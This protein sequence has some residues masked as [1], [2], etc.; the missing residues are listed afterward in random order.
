MPIEPSL[1]AKGLSGRGR[2]ALVFALALMPSVALAQGEPLSAIDW[3]SDTVAHPTAKPSPMEAPVR[4]PATPDKITTSTLLDRNLDAVSVLPTSITGIDRRF[5]SGSSSAALTDLIRQERAEA[6]PA[7]RDLLQ[8][9]MLAELDPPADSDGSGTFL[10]VRI[11]KLLELGA[12]EAASALVQAAGKPTPEL[13]RRAFDI[14]LLLATEDQACAELRATPQI[15]PT[16]PA[17]IFCLARGGNWPAAE[18]TLRTAQALGQVTDEED[19]LLERFLAPGDFEDAE[20]LP[21]PE[22]LSPLVLRIY[23]AIG[24]PIAASSLPLAFAHGDLTPATGW[25]ARL[26]AAER[27]ARTAAIAPGQLFSLYRERRPAA[28][29]G[30]WTRVAAVQ[31][32]EA[33]LRER[34]LKRLGTELDTTWSVLADQELEVPFAEIH[35]ASLALLPLEGDAGNLAFRIGLLGP[36]YEKI[37]LRRTPVDEMETFLIGIARGR[38][39]GTVPPY[40]MARAIAPVFGAD[41]TAPPLSPAMQA[42]VEEGRRGEAALLAIDK[43]TSGVFGDL[44]GVTDGLTTLRHLGLEGSARRAALQ[45]MLLERRG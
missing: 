29:G 36:G 3:L 19:A 10:L 33:A 12:L 14:S 4:P 32:F 15:A 43:V 20:P 6:L 38:L 1:S 34:D 26:E 41:G 5:W 23:E 11:D 18:L 8:T 25:K 30:V 45:L 28:S 7:L 44:R 35:A 27:L 24:E 22:R 2:L 21:L 40:G 17:R 39:A 37:A 13:F 42:M 31:R 16:F 9:L